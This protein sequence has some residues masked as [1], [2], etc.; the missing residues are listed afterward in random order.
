M[1]KGCGGDA[2][3]GGGGGGGGGVVLGVFMTRR[4]ESPLFLECDKILFPDFVRQG[5]Q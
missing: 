5:G 1:K 3:G 4:I 2:G